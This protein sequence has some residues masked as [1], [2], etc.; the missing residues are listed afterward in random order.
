MSWRLAKSL[1][2]LRKQIDD[3][4]PNRDKS[5]DG[6]VGNL[7]H[8][9]TKSDHNPNSRGVVQA[10]DITH[11]PKGGFDSY[12]FADMLRLKK[13]PRIKYIISNSRIANPDAQNWK[14]RPYNGANPHDHH[15]HISVK[16]APTLYDSTMPWDIDLSPKL[17]PRPGGDVPPPILR[18]GDTGTFVTKLQKL[19]GF[20]DKDVDE[21]FG[22]ST[23][24]AVVAFQKAHGL[25][26]DGVVGA[27]TW[28]ELLAPKSKEK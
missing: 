7:A 9:Q 19:L 13:D 10:I 24:A 23:E 20:L 25:V 17:E 4:V 11:D 15:V 26:G 5:S 27:Y 18:R 28:R 2:Q 22:K 8:Q 1:I 6:S 14:W 21:R 12:K 3:L 16:D